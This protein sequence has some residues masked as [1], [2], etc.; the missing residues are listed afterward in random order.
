MTLKQFL[1]AVR[2]NNQSC[3]NHLGTGQYRAHPSKLKLLKTFIHSMLQYFQIK[4]MSN[5]SSEQYAKSIRKHY[6]I[7][8]KNHNV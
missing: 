1:N 5:N 6:G 7:F 4:L 8:R 2:T 3:K